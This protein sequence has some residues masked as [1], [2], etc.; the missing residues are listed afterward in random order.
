[1]NTDRYTQKTNEAIENAQKMAIKNNNPQI[2][3]EH[4]HYG[5][6][7]VEDSLIP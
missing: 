4:M 2:E 5:L 3:S 7:T 6:L 1:M